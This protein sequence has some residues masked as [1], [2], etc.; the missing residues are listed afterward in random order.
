MRIYLQMSVILSLLIPLSP[1]SLNKYYPDNLRVTMPQ[2]FILSADTHS[3]T[4]DRKISAVSATAN[5]SVMEHAFNRVDW[6]KTGCIIYFGI[7]GFFILCVL[8]QFLYIFR[9]KRDGIIEKRQGYLL[10][11]NHSLGSSFSF[12]NW[13][14]INPLVT[15]A[16]SMERIILHEVAH[17]KQYHS[18]DSIMI[19]I[20]ACFMWFNPAVWLLRGSMQQVHEFL[21]DEA[22]LKEGID[23]FRYQAI[24]LNQLAEGPVFSLF[25]GFNRSLLKN[26]IAMMTIKKASGSISSRIIT[27]SFIIG[28]LFITVGCF[29]KNKQESENDQLNT[30]SGFY[31][32]VAPVKMNVL[33]LGVEN[34]V[35]IAVSG[36]PLDEIQ[37]SI[38]NGTIRRD[39]AGRFIVAPAKQGE[40]KIKLM[41][42]NKEIGTRVFRVKILPT[43]E[44]TIGGMRGG[45]ITKEG[46]LKAGGIS[47]SISNFDFDVNTRVIYFKVSVMGKKNPILENIRNSNEF[48]AAQIDMI[49]GLKPGQKVYFE[50]IRGSIPDGTTRELGGIILTID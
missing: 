35:E 26:R 25:S 5:D 38:D 46:L 7:A 50:D 30:G 9:I 14:F 33:Y 15:D 18:I 42:E 36:V 16:E 32:A 2:S 49:K 34:P 23:K 20:T 28:L 19:N 12:M 43:P 41:K 31:A 39:E 6:L 10:I 27:M 37:V 11:K 47:C 3:A 45:V 17:V 21:A 48:T 40:A 44:A 24:L 29:K 1:Y 22:V 8:F 13:I 4:T